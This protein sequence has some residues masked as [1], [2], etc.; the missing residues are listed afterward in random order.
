MD[1]KEMKKPDRETLMAEWMQEH[2]DQVEGKFRPLQARIKKLAK[3][4]HQNALSAALENLPNDSV[5]TAA[6]ERAI[7]EEIQARQAD[8]RPQVAAVVES[9]EALEAIEIRHALRYNDVEEQ[10]KDRRKQ[11]LR[12]RVTE[13]S[14]AQIAESPQEYLALET[15]LRRLEPKEARPE[16]GVMAYV[17]HGVGWADRERQ[18]LEE[19]VDG[20]DRCAF[21]IHL[22]RDQFMALLEKPG[23]GKS[24]FAAVV[25]WLAQSEMPAEWLGGK[26]PGEQITMSV[27]KAKPTGYR[28]HP[29]NWE[30][31]FGGSEESL[32]GDIEEWPAEKESDRRLRRRPGPKV[33]DVLT[34]TYTGD[35]RLAGCE[36]EMVEGAIGD[37]RITAVGRGVVFK[38]PDPASPGR[39]S[40]ILPG[41]STQI[42][43]EPDEEGTALTPGY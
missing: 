36:Y 7:T 23:T 5:A 22:T 32:G 2:R 18:R 35:P 16:D 13:M 11:E 31:T 28:P 14:P 38:E 1:I 43:V 27:N 3:E 33:G 26:L 40:Q 4:G 42:I 6:I 41:E 37:V 10:W 19:L 8:L 15:A 39:S 34:G 29:A 17:S 30:I 24:A 9:L 12:Q 21:D 20:S 25:V